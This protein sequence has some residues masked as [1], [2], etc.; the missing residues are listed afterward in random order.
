M[1]AADRTKKFATDDLSSI[2]CIDKNVPAPNAY[3]PF[4]SIADDQSKLKVK[5]FGEMN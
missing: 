1:F 2:A 5:R 4:G 3:E